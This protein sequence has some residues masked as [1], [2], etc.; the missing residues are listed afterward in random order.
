MGHKYVCLCCRKCF[1]AGTDFTKFQDKKKCPDCSA[2]MVLL[3]EKFK[4]P[5][6][7]NT[8]Q[9]E[10]IKMLVDNGF[11][12]QTMYN[13]DSGDRIPYPRTKIEAEEFI[14]KNKK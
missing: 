8:V 5:P 7:E 13:S 6:K 1:S 14:R 11:N 12:Y 3:N 9:W 2:P 10:I 4:A